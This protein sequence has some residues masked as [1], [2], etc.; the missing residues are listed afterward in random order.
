MTTAARFHSAARWISLAALACAS[1]T[2]HAGVEEVRFYTPG[3]DAIPTRVGTAQ[4]GGSDLCSASNQVCAGTLG[5]DSITAGLVKAYAY[6]GPAPQPLVIQNL[7]PSQTGLGVLTDNL[8]DTQGTVDQGEALSLLF[9]NPVEVV[10]F[11]FFNVHHE[12]FAPDSSAPIQ[13]IVDERFYLLNP[14]D[15]ALPSGIT[16]REFTLLGGPSPYYL[17]AVRI[18][19]VP[20]PT[21]LSLMGLGLTALAVARRRRG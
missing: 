2:A 13:L 18:T 5:F 15:T 3:T 20:E 21:T 14:A 12:A 11:D 17:G 4:E 10:G 1:L 19:A 16:G 8:T 7:A 6:A 9:A